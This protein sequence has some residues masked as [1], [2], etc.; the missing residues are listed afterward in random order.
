MKVAIGVLAAIVVLGGGWWYYSTQMMPAADTA[1][2]TT[3]NT[4]NTTNNS[5]TPSPSDQGSTT[6]NLTINTPAAAAS[7]S[8]MLLE[9]GFSPKTVTIKKGGTVTWADESAGNMWVAT[10]SH[11]THTV[12]D[13]TALAAHCAAGANAPSF[14]QCKNGTSYSFTFNKVGTWNYHNHSNSPQFGSVVVVE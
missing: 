1:P 9:S 10:A 3:N 6:V 7:A 14:D 5:N 4:T 8:V 11:P 2:D 13:G 12:Y